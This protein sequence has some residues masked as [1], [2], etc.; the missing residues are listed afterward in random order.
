[1]SRK[2]GSVFVYDLII[3]YIIIQIICILIQHIWLFHIDSFVYIWSFS[4]KPKQELMEQFEQHIR[5]ALVLLL[6]FQVIIL[7]SR[8]SW[9][10]AVE[11]A[12]LQVVATQCAL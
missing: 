4:F 12:S 2:S 7:V 11:L 5:H 8:L 10:C 6:P 9:C 3:F 1:M